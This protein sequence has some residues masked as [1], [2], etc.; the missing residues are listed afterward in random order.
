MIVFGR[1]GGS[2]F[3]WVDWFGLIAHPRRRRRL[4]WYRIERLTR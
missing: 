4:R 2:L 1:I 3:L